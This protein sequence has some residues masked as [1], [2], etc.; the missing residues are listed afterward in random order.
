[1]QLKLG[2]NRLAKSHIPHFDDPNMWVSSEGMTVATG[3][4][5]PRREK[6]RNTKSKRDDDEFLDAS[7]GKEK[8]DPGMIPSTL[9]VCVCSFAR[10]EL[11]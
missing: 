11:V 5:A 9:C 3:G 1:V 6:R 4:H 10:G 8:Q 2:H 7:K